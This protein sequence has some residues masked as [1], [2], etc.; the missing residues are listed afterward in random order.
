[1][2][3]SLLSPEGGDGTETESRIHTPPSRMV[4][5][6]HRSSKTQILFLRTVPGP[7]ELFRLSSITGVSITGVSITGVSITGVSITGV[8]ITGVSITGVSI[9]GV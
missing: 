2:I 9:T 3:N 5:G 7:H 6:P 8:S 1:M 4:P